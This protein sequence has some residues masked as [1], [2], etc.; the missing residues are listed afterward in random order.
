MRESGADE[1]AFAPSGR[2]RRMRLHA[3]HT[4]HAQRRARCTVIVSRALYLLLLVLAVAPLANVVYR[5]ARRRKD[6]NALRN[7]VYELGSCGLADA[8]WVSPCSV[9]ASRLERARCS[10]VW[11]A[12]P[13]FAPALFIRAMLQKIS[14]EV[15]ASW[16]CQTRIPKKHP[17]SAC[18]GDAHAHSADPRLIQVFAP[19]EDLHPHLLSGDIHA[20]RKALVFVP[21]SF[22]YA[23]AVV[24]YGN[25]NMERNISIDTAFAH[26][27]AVVLREYLEFWQQRSTEGLF[28]DV[29]F[30]RLESVLPSSPPIEHDGGA[31]DVG[32]TD[33]SEREWY[34]AA[35]YVGVPNAKDR[36]LCALRSLSEEQR[37]DSLVSD[38]LIDASGN[39]A[40]T[41]GDAE[42]FWTMPGALARLS[43]DTIRTLTAAMID[44]LCAPLFLNAS[45][46]VLL[47]RLGIAANSV[48][49]CS[50]ALSRL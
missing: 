41:S 14:G 38:I 43:Y 35:A 27:V 44:L 23:L 6:A 12:L 49:D 48:D 37:R 20:K 34:Q 11:V 42:S 47:P 5:A 30:V 28:S 24:R 4:R 8:V 33:G 19:F 2:T 16:T 9:T 25:Y 29:R 10:G 18:A 17:L 40:I 31:V 46:A 7:G 3:I 45:N 39:F 15:V 32:S 13:P 50:S 1:R 36:V 21:N 26:H 22:S